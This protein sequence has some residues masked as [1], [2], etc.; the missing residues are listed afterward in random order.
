M[1]V[2]KG[3]FDNMTAVVKIMAWRRSGYKSLSETMIAKFADAYLRDSV[4]MN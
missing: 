3:P 2:P 1:F 4:S